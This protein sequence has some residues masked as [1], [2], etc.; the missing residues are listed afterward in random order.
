MYPATPSINKDT[1]KN[2]KIQKLSALPVELLKKQEAL[3]VVAV[4]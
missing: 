1:K 3:R 2:V 4:K